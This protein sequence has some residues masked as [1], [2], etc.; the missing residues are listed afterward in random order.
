MMIKPPFIAD[1]EPLFRYGAS[2]SLRQAGHVVSEA[3][4]V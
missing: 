2:L 3:L 4:S 1:Q